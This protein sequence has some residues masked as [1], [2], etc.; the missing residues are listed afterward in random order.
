MTQMKQLVVFSMLSVLLFIS[1]DG[2]VRTAQSS[3]NQYEILT[4]QGRTLKLNTV[5]GQTWLLDEDSIWKPVSE[6]AE[7]SDSSRRSYTGP[8]LSSFE[9]GAPGCAAPGLNAQ[10]LGSIV[11]AAVEPLIAAAKYNPKTQQLEPMSADARNL[12]I[13][14]AVKR[15]FAAYSRIQ[16]QFNPDDPLGVLP[17]L[18]NQRH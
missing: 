7:R 17:P 12:E 11:E 9:H 6:N 2:T 3:G 16:P 1:C 13:Q 8:P 14:S 4:A 5:T 15:A 18:D 10:Q